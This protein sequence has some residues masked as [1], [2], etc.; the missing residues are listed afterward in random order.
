MGN[1]YRAWAKYARTLECELNQLAE[2]NSD[3]ADF[4]NEFRI[5]TDDGSARY[6]PTEIFAALRKEVA[7]LK[8]ELAA[9]RSSP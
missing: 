5:D 9:K 4:I 3:M 6:T 2:A 1:R 7:A 8:T